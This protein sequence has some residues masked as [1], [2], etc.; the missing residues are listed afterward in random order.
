MTTY[1]DILPVEI[2]AHIYRIYLVN[3]VNSIEFKSIHRRLLRTRLQ[4]NLS[5]KQLHQLGF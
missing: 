2:C 1:L 4:K 5:Q 3:I